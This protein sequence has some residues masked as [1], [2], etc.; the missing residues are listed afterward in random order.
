MVDFGTGADRGSGSIG[1]RSGGVLRR[2]VWR[3]VSKKESE[4]VGET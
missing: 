1:Y 2:G 4:F 3:R